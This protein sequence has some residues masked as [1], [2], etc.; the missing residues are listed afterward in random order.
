MARKRRFSDLQRALNLLRPAAG[1]GNEGAAPDAPP[2]TRLRFYQDWKKGAREV[3]YTR[4]TSSNPGSFEERI[5]ELFGAG[6]TENRALVP[7]SRRALDGISNTGLDI[8]N[9]GYGGPD[10]TYPG[11]VVPAKISIYL[12]GA[13]QTTPER[14]RLT[15]TPYKP[16][17][18]SRSFTYPFGRTGTDSYRAK[19]LGLIT[20][21][22]ARDGVVGASCRPEDLIL[23]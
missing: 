19:A 20:T 22:K 13:R 18:N 17:A 8:T 7:V 10:A 3:T 2:G 4:Q 23:N 12:G 9:L 15:G 21:A 16:R 11:Q 14:S 5:I 6:T 1:G